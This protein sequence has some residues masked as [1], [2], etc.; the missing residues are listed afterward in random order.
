[1]SDITEMSM[2][3]Y[4]KKKKKRCIP[5][6]DITGQNIINFK[7]YVNLQQIRNIDT[8]ERYNRGEHYKS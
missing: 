2:L 7:E 6:S 5:M 4:K 1:M 3:T 8:N